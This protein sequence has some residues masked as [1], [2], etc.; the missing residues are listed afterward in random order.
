MREPK[1]KPAFRDDERL[2]IRS[3]QE[4]GWF[5]LVRSLNPKGKLFSWWSRPDFYLQNKGLRLDLVFGSR[6]VVDR[7]QS[8]Q[9]VHRPYEDRGR[10]G[11][12]D[13]APVIVDLD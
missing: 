3:L 10:S 2:R 9:I 5:D 13:H 7:A 8:A 4:A 11:E 12:V 6:A 1:S